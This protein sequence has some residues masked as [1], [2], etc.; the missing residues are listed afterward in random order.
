MR[1]PPANFLAASHLTMANRCA[2]RDY[3]IA[4]VP[5]LLEFAE[6]AGAPCESYAWWCSVVTTLKGEAAEGMV[7]AE[8]VQMREKMAVVS[9][10]RARALAMLGKHRDISF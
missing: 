10:Q 9:P 2:S 3:T 5:E 6:A 4:E 1:Q 8:I 7:E